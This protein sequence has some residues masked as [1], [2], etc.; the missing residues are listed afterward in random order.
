MAATETPPAVLLATSEDSGVNAGA[1]LGA[2]LTR[3]G[4]RGGGSAQLAQGTVENTEVLA[5]VL[6]TLPLRAP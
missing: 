1:M 5:S 4:G 3:A 2:A 6:E